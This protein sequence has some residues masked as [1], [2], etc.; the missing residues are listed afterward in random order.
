MRASDHGLVK[1]VWKG[2]GL[3]ESREESVQL[4][5]IDGSKTMHM[6]RTYNSF[7][8]FPKITKMLRSL[9]RKEQLTQRTGDRYRR[10]QF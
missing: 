5:C 9:P 2:G 4:V 1:V 7:R 3:F 6:F 8:A 10:T